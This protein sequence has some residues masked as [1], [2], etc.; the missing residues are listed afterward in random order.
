MFEFYIFSI[1]LY[2]CAIYITVLACSPR[3]M[4]NGWL[5]GKYSEA[6]PFLV[7]LCVSAIPIFRALF[8][9]AAF[10]MS[11]HTKEEFDAEQHKLDM[12]VEELNQEYEDLKWIYEKL[13]EDDE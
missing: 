12:E 11:N 8:I 2:M 7:L 6:N 1:F 5:D 13:Q 4:M 9:I 3:I 10:Y